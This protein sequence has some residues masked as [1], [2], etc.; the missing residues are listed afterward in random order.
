VFEPLAPIPLLE[1]LD[2]RGIGRVHVDQDELATQGGNI[3]AVRPGVVV[4]ADGNPR[5]RRAL[6][7]AG[8]EVHVYAASELNK[9]DGGPTCLTR[10]IL[11]AQ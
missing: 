11:R 6:E 3:L 10:P 8:V 4:M 2:E 9:G 1:A 5:T 7:A